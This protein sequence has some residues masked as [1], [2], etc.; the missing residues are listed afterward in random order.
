MSGN[1]KLILSL[2]WQL[3]TRYQLG[4]ASTPPK[5]LMLSWLEAALP[6]LKITNFT[7]GK[8]DKEKMT[9]KFIENWSILILDWN[10]GIALAALVDFCKP[11]IFADWHQLNPKL[12]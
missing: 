1:L 7:K 12:K 11:G 10:S 6:E 2:L 9:I 4:K 8:Q 3:I 5:K